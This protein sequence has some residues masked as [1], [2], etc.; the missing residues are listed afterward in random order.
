MLFL[1]LPGATLVYAWS[2]QEEKGGMA[3]PIVAAFVA[4]VGLMGSFNGLNTYAAGLISLL[5]LGPGGHFVCCFMDEI[6]NVVL[7]Y[8]ST[9]L[10]S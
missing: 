8:R 5:F 6:A 7:R 4:G 9:P 1:V 2:L 10:P 3:L